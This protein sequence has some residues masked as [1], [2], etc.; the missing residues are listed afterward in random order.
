MRVE[1][2]HVIFDRIDLNRRGL[3]FLEDSGGVG[4]KFLTD[5]IT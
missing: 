1:D 4:M 2:V 3:T 5:V